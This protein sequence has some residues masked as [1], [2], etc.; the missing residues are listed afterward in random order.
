MRITESFLG[1][2][3][4]LLNRVRERLWVRPAAMC[5]VSILAA[6]GNDEMK[7]AAKAHARFALQHAEKALRLPDEIEALRE[8]ALK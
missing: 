6:L 7:A 3:R 4:F 2:I 8:V 5:V 1:R